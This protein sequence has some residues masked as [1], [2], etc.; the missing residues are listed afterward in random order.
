MVGCRR[1]PA[2]LDFG[3]SSRPGQNGRQRP[4]K[5]LPFK[6]RRPSG[7]AIALTKRCSTSL[8]RNDPNAQLGRRRNDQ[9]RRGQIQP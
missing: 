1:S 3:Q 9:D 2:D 7:R 6:A 5:V 8:S 4:I